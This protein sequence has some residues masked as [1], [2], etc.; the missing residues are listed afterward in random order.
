MKA[1][2]VHPDGRIEEAEL[3]ADQGLDIAHRF[4]GEDVALDLARVRYEGRLCT[5]AVDDGG[6]AKDLPVNEIATRA[7]HANCIPG[8]THQIRG[9]AVIFDR[10]L[11]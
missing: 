7:Y 6:H 1:F 11:P 3:R 10:V 4:I 9:T 2:A 5:M 8:T